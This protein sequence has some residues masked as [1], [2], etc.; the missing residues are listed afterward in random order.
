M[1][2]KASGGAIE[3]RDAYCAAA[4]GEVVHRAALKPTRDRSGAAAGA[5][6]QPP[7][8]RAAP[9]RPPCRPLRPADPPAFLPPAP[10]GKA[11]TKKKVPKAEG[12]KEGAKKGGKK[13]G[14]K[15]TER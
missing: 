2:P 8:R 12:A 9:A 6:P 5:A 14:I 1:A 13:R 11:P 15:G 3:R 10:A 4:A 7:L